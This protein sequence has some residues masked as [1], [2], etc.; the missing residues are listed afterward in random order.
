M[1]GSAMVNQTATTR[2]DVLAVAGWLF[3]ANSLRYAPADMPFFCSCFE[4]G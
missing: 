3:P 1:G 2:R 4:K